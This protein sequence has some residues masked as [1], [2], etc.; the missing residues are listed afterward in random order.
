MT[1]QVW[2]SL[3]RPRGF[4]IAGG[5]L[6]R[7]PSAQRRTGLLPEQASPVR[8]PSSNNKGKGSI[9]SSFRRANSFA[10]QPKDPTPKTSQPFR[11][12][13]TLPALPAVANN[14]ESSTAAV[15][16][17]PSLFA[18]LKFVALGE[19]RCPNVRAAIEGSGGLMVSEA[20]DDVDYIVV[21]LVRYV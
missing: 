17:C 20:D 10:P 11:R 7:S 5:K 4:E 14:G 3:L 18:G 19:A 12:T 13:S 21:R 9:I 16:S 6:V 1:L 8:L 15:A 2:A